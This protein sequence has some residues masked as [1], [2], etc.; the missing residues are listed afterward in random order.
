MS[1]NLTDLQKKRKTRF[2]ISRIKKLIQLN[3]NIGKTTSTVPVVISRAI[4]L[5]MEDLIEKMIKEAK[6]E[7]STK[8]VETH[9]NTVVEREE[10][11]YGFLKDA[12]K[13]EDDESEAECE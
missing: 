5:F 2:P 3:E 10:S 6:N 1:T 7:D 12:V 8:L 4:E 11:M 9:Y 13:E